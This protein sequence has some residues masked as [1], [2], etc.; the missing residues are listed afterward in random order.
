MSIG[1]I[2][3]FVISLCSSFLV[4]E[5]RTGEEHRS[6]AK[7]YKDA[8]QAQGRDELFKKH[9]ARYYAMSRLKY[10]DAVRMS[11]ID[12]MHN[13]LLGMSLIIS[14]PSGLNSFF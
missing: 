14:V 1:I 6:H 2:L 8:Q 5:P 4:H 3:G 9:G 10:F 12:P 11:A 13:I 7:A